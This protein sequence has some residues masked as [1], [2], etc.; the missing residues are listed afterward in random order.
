MFGYGRKQGNGGTPAPAAYAER[1]TFEPFGL[2]RAA[3][4]LW[5]ILPF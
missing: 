5:V 2:N 4:F 3:L 1:A